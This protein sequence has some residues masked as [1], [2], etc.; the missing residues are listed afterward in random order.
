MICADFLAGASLDEG[1]RGPA[2]FGVSTLQ[3]LARRGEATLS[4]RS[5]AHECFTHFVP[6][7]RS[8]R[9][10]RDEYRRLWRQI[11]ESDGWCCQN[12]G[13][14]VILQVQHILHRSQ[15]GDDAEEN[16]VTLCFPAVTPKHTQTGQQLGDD[17]YER[18][19]G[20]CDTSCSRAESDFAIRLSKQSN[21]SSKSSRR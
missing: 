14:R 21:N 16:L 19:S 5:N 9:L 2:Q 18:A 8:I 20:R 4:G 6:K 12:C 13:S 3:V 17:L 10:S 15:A 1:N 11:L 7:R